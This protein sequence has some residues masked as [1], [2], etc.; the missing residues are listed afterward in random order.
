MKKPIFL[1]LVFILIIFMA[2]C[3]PGLSD[4][5][6][7]DRAAEILEE[8]GDIHPKIILKSDVADML[9]ELVSDVSF[10]D[11]VADSKDAAQESTDAEA[12]ASGTLTIGD[13]FVFD[14][15]E[16]TVLGTEV[17]PVE[18]RYS[19]YEDAVLINLSVKNISSET[20][21]LN[22]FYYTAFGSKGTQVSTSLDA[23]FDEAEAST[24]ELRP[25]AS[26]ESSL[27]I[28]YDGDGTYY[29]AFDNWDDVIEV[30]LDI[31]K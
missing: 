26:L 8:Q 4:E 25:D 20:H 30:E 14:G 2:G 24:T 15:L 17:K 11:T 7:L 16:I 22:M 13:T 27:A 29:L 18:N 12:S 9:D 31:V 3:S 21:G 5:E 10:D 28:E 23:Y 19:D 6:I 1:V